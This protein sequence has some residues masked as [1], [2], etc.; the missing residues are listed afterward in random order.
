MRI[1]NEFTG[2]EISVDASRPLT[3]AKI[4]AW[5]RKLHAQDC[6]SGD[7][8]GGRGPQDDQAG[9]D[10]LLERAQGVV[11][12]RRDEPRSYINTRSD[13]YLSGSEAYQAGEKASDNPYLPGTF[14]FDNW[15]VGFRTSRSVEGAVDYFMRCSPLVAAIKVLGGGAE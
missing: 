13:A 5:R 6:T 14:E 1:R 2:R 11:S 10:A 9:Y 8:L 3:L 7:D 12:S 4:R 15:D